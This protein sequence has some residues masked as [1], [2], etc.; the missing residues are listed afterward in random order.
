MKYKEILLMSI[1]V[2]IALSLSFAVPDGAQILSNTTETKT[3]DSAASI[4]STGGS[5]TTIILNASTQNTRWKAYA[6]NVTGVLTLDDDNTYTIYQWAISAYTGE[7]YASRNDSITWADI[8]CA[9]QENITNEDTAMNHTT[10]S[11]DSINT[12]FNQEIHK[13]FYV[14]NVHIPESSCRSTFT[15]VNDTA[16]TPSVDAPYA[17]VLLHDGEHMVY[18]TFIDDNVQGFNY[19]NY[20]FQMEVLNLK[21]DLIHF[22]QHKKDFSFI[23]GKSHQLHMLSKGIYQQLKILQ[24]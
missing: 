7:V 3:P 21:Q 20:D 13:E 14:G 22:L 5:F 10:T 2:I 18:T 8:S 19:N 6:G 11:I 24:V 16:Q 9:S 12:T 23:M 1:I 15:W 17:E 4:N